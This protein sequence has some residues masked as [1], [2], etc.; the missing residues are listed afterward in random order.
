MGFVS[1]LSAGKSGA[2]S[3]IKMRAHEALRIAVPDAPFARRLPAWKSCQFPA[4]QNW[5]I[6]G[7]SPLI[8][9]VALTPPLAPLAFLSRFGVTRSPN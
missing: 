5:R 1:S 7:Y 4:E 6:R 3:Q 9:V 2:F 8:E